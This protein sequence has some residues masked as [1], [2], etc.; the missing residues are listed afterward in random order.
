MIKGTI[1]K[2]FTKN[3]AH[4]AASKAERNY[5]LNQISKS[6]RSSGHRFVRFRVRRNAA[7]LLR[8]WEV[9]ND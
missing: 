7:N 1:S 6:M 3:G 4:I 2:H 8:K 5:R 9:Y